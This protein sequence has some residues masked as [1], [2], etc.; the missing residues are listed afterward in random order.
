MTFTHA[1]G[2]GP[3]GVREGGAGRHEHHGADGRRPGDLL[4]G[5]TGGDRHQ[6]RAQAGEPQA[7]G[8][9]GHSRLVGPANRFEKAY[10]HAPSL[11]A[12][13]APP[14]P[15]TARA[16]RRPALRRSATA[17]RTGPEG[18]RRSEEDRHTALEEADDRCQG[19]L[20]HP[21]GRLGV[22]GQFHRDRH[23]LAGRLLQLPHHHMTGMGGRSPMDEAAGV[24]GHVRPD[25]PG[26]ADVG[27]GAIEDVTRPF[28]GAQ[29]HR[30]RAAT[31]GRHVQRRGQ[32][33]LQT[34]GPP[35][36]PEWGRRGDL[37]GDRL[38][39]TAA[40]RHQRDD[41]I[42]RTPPA[43]RPDE[44]LRT[45][46]V[47]RSDPHAAAG[48]DAHLHRPAG[49]A[50]TRRAPHGDPR[51]RGDHEGP[52]DPDEE[53]TEDEVAQHLH[54]ARARIVGN[55]PPQADDQTRPRPSAPTGGP[56]APS[57][58]RSGRWGRFEKLPDH[59]GRSGGVAVGLDGEDAVRE[60]VDG[61]RLHVV[62]HHVRPG[63]RGRRGPARRG[64]AG[65]RPAGSRRRA[66]RARSGWPRQR[67]TA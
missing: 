29:G 3:G 67:S 63:A 14:G 18:S 65:W 40:Q 19:T 8:V 20:R 43:G 34:F 23:R 13:V 31:A 41:A 39:D 12:A 25:A 15:L 37:E 22:L 49:D 5:G 1:G 27:P 28:V 52:H 60:A 2:S 17:P 16:R 57:G 51:P 48:L 11:S 4:Q 10:R 35:L 61:H 62:G 32:G 6:H 45:G 64:G 53:G 66:R 44:R 26:Q 33:E 9:L 58:S 50:V 30:L 46:W 7:D 55:Q 59:G 47:D 36:Q 54:P 21:L 24:A 56:A 38:V 42:D